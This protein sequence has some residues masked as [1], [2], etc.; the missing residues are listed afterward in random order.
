MQEQQRP[1]TNKSFESLQDDFVERL[2][3]R[4]AD[5]LGA[6]TIVVLPSLSLPWEELKKIYAT[7][8][9]EERLLFT[10]LWLSRPDVRIIYLSSIDIDDGVIDYHLDFIDQRADARGRLHMVSTANAIPGP[11]SA[12]LLDSTDVL[13]RIR[14]LVDDPGDA[15]VLP[16]NVTPLERALCERIGVPVYGP[17]PDLVRIGS[18]SEGRRLARSAGIDVFEGVEDL[19][20]VEEIEHAIARVRELRPDATAVVLKL[21]NGFSGKGNAIVDLGTYRPPLDD[22]NTT[23]CATEESWAS[24]GPKIRREGAIVE[25]LA[26]MP[27]AVSPSV[28][29][30]IAPGG[31]VEVISTHDQLLGGPDDQI[32]LGSRFPARTDYAAAIVDKACRVADL[33]ASKGVIGYFGIDF[34]AVPEGGSHRFFLSEINLRMLGTTHTYFMTQLVTGGRYDPE[35]GRFEAADGPKVYVATDNLVSP[36]YKGLRPEAVVRALGDRGVAYDSA[37]RTGA[38]L[39]MLGALNRYGKL[40][41]TCIANS[42]D[43][44]DDV[45]AAVTATLDELAGRHPSP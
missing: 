20:S 38:T 37:S 5:D 9:Y 44:A 29:M 23:F 12:K 26:R 40:G 43:E 14:G 7:R 3:Q 35:S 34:V 45:Y 31:R 13:A 8:H 32:F 18:K 33:L 25:E 2:S 11:L 1:R 21:N 10:L 6:R 30:K 28:Q 41:A 22:S 24:F 27:G 15:Y 4:P 16:Y 19:Y 17:H 36:S 42:P 39:H